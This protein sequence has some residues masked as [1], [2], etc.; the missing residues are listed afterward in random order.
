MLREAGSI[1]KPGRSKSLRKHKPF[2][3]TE[4]KV[5]KNQYPHGF[6]CEQYISFLLTLTMKAKRKDCIC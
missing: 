2:L 3:D 6:I 4:V 1:Y 5:V